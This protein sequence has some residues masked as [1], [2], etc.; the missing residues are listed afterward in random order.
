LSRWKW[1]RYKLSQ[2]CR[3]KGSACK[4]SRRYKL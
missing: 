3:K 4:Q 2:S 1:G